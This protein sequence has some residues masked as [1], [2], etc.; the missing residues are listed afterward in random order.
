MEI[1]KEYLKDKGFLPRLSFQQ[2]PKATVKIL[3]GEKRTIPTGGGE[4]V[5]GLLFTVEENG[6]KKELFTASLSLIRQLADYDIG[7]VL[8]IEMKKVKT[9]KGY[10]S[11]FEVK[12]AGEIEAVPEVP[13][14]EIP[15][16]DGN[17]GM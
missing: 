11:T 2:Q 1:A 6:E 15:V 9:D 5:E 7:D 13:D 4:E 8:I 10:R 16:L 12:P 3:K 17:E 14:E